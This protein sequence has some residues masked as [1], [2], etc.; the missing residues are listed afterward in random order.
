MNIKKLASDATADL[1]ASNAETALQAAIEL[2]LISHPTTSVI[3][4]LRSWAAYLE[5]RQ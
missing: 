2:M 5:D 4:R 1:F 3:E